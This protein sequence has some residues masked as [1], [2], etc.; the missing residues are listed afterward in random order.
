MQHVKGEENIIADA[1]SIKLHGVYEL[2]YNQIECKFLEQ[3]KEEGK[4]DPEYQFMWQQVEEAKKQEKY[5]DYGFSKD[6]LLTFKER[7]YVPN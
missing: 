5:V 4:K 2:Y 3:V 1:L 6:Q 7:I